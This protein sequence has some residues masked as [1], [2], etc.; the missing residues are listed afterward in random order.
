MLPDDVLI[1]VFDFY[2]EEYED[3][4][5]D[6][7]VWGWIILVH[8]CRSWRQVVFASPIHLDLKILCTSGTPVRKN[9]GIWPALP[10]VIIIPRLRMTM[11]TISLLHSGTPI[12]CVV[13]ALM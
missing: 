9:I 12:V 3:E 8:I 5:L 1:E 10:I 6:I 4:N 11:K 2:R 7:L 13:L